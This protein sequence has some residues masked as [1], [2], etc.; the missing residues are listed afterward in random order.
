MEPA[1]K[2]RVE[3]ARKPR[4][5][6]ARKPR[7]EPA[8]KPRVE[9]ARKPRAE[10]ARKPY[11]PKV[12]HK[13]HPM[14]DIK[15]MMARMIESF[16]PAAARGVNAHFQINITGDGGGVYTLKVADQKVEVLSNV[17]QNPTVA[18]EVS[19]ANWAAIL[20]G[21]L[22]AANAFMTG[23]LRISGDMSQMLK[24]REMFKR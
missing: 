7:V 16:D 4:V 8:R 18:I 19:A 15:A 2:P 9:P 5:E 17:V 6:R 12:C 20:S 22:D 24:F 11:H 23:K 3:P 21:E 10:R 13:M 1:R 14:S